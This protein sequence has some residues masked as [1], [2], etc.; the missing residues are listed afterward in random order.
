MSSWNIALVDSSA[1]MTSN[2][3]SVNK[4]IIDLFNDQRDN[5]DRF[6]FITFNTIVKN[7]ADA[8]FNE[9]NCEDIIN[10]I[11]NVG[12]TA[13]YDA[14]GHVYKMIIAENFKNVSLTI[15]TDGYENSSKIHT[16]V[17]LKNLRET[18]DEMCNL[19]VSFICENEHDLKNNSAIISHANE[20]CEVSGDYVEAFRNIS[21]SMSYSR[22]PSV[23]QIYSIGNENENENENE[24]MSEPIVKRQNSYAEKKRPR[25]FF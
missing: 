8:N 22:P 6:T 20:S 17:S 5:T 23:N 21:R 2:Q 12:L 3:N 10:S 18:I 1:S 16:L 4:G 9:I 25:L 19:N 15:I 11:L 24:S 7:I 14:I 13:L